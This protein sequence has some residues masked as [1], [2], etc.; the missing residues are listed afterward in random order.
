MQKKKNSGVENTME[1]DWIKKKV[2]SAF[3]V[4]KGHRPSD[5]LLWTGRQPIASLCIIYI[6]V[7]HQVVSLARKFSIRNLQIVLLLLLSKK[8]M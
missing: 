7:V 3:P 4:V 6:W 5:N 1:L 8:V 2:F